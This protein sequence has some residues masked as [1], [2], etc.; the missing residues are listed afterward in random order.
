[1]SFDYVPGHTLMP[2]PTYYKPIPD[3]FRKVFF[4]DFI[5]IFRFPYFEDGVIVIMDLI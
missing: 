2:Y 1:M 3:V 5:S 4:F